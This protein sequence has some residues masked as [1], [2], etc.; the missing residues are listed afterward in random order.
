MAHE[1]VSQPSQRDRDFRES[2]LDKTAWQNI[3]N[4]TITTVHATPN[5]QPGGV[6][7]AL[8]RA[9]YQSDWTPGPVNHPPIASPPKLISKMQANSGMFFKFMDSIKFKG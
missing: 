1:T 2:A 3:L 7:G 9:A 6:H 8:G 4:P 5:T